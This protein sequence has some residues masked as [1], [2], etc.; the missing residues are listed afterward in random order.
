MSKW[1]PLA[2]EAKCINLI[3]I[4]TET[5]RQKNFRRHLLNKVGAADYYSWF[6]QGRF[7]LL[8]EGR[9]T[10]EP[11]NI[12]AEGQWKTYSWLPEWIERFNSSKTL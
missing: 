10:F 1:E 4:S 11:G 7:R 5:D 2:D 12:I 9:Y 6:S 3:R 8:D